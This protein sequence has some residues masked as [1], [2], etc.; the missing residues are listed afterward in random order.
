MSILNTSIFLIIQNMVL[1]FFMPIPYY[2]VLNSI[3]ILHLKINDPCFILSLKDL[4]EWI[5]PWLSPRRFMDYG[6][7]CLK[8]L[9]TI[10]QLYHGGQFYRW[11]KPEYPE[12]NHRPVTS[13]WQALSQNVVLSTPRHMRREWYSNSQ[14]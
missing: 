11:R 4:N 2:F 5:C 3:I 9:P 12:G 6:L 13:H 1:T 10:F 14:L 7:R 8:P